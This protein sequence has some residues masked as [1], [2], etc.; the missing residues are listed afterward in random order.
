VLTLASL[1]VVAA[2]KDDTDRVAEALGRA[3]RM[4][5]QAVDGPGMGAVLQAQAEIARL[6]GAPDEAR[7]AL[8]GALTVFYGTT[9][10]HYY[11]AWLHLQHAFLSLEVG[12][13]DESARRIELARND[14]ADSGTTL[15]LDYCAA[16]EQALTPR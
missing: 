13:V 2:M 9:G 7:Q 4:A 5:D 6:R 15:G 3:R 11:A 16:I 10:L 12:D 8:D 1:A 14:F